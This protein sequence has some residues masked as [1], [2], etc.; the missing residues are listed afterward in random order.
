MVYISGLL[1]PGLPR[2]VQK[3]RDAIYVGGQEGHFLEKLKIRV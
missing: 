1:S 3:D 2:R